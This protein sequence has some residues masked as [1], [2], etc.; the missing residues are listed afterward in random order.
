MEIR[1]GFGSHHFLMNPN[2]ENQQDDFDFA[3][4]YDAVDYQQ[5]LAL[6]K[7]FA[8]HVQERK[9]QDQIAERHQ[10]GMAR[11][12]KRASRMNSVP[13]GSAGLFTKKATFPSVY[14][15][16]TSALE[17]QQQQQQHTTLRST[18]ATTTTTPSSSGDNWFLIVLLTFT[19]HQPIV[20]R[21]L[22]VSLLCFLWTSVGE[23]ALL[24]SNHLYTSPTVQEWTMIPSRAVQ[25]MSMMPSRAVPE[26]TTLTPSAAGMD[27]RLE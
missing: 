27:S 1:S 2:N 4:L 14:S 11:A 20:S 18:T 21:L 19:T 9:R 13:N 15:T 23:E 17:Q 3:N 24:V 7:D 10:L 26:L 22:L 6:S 12:Q 16:P 5:G 8:E 25:E